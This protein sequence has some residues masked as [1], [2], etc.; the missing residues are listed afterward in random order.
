[1]VNGDLYCWDF[2]SVKSSMWIIITIYL[3]ILFIFTEHFVYIVLTKC[4]LFSSVSS[5]LDYMHLYYMT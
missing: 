5:L 3:F 4:A 2:Q 1:M